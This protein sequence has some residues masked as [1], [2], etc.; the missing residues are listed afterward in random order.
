MP[1]VSNS[2]QTLPPVRSGVV[3]R[4]L[5]S[6]AVFGFIGQYIGH[7][8]G[9]HIENNKVAGPAFRWAM[10]AF[11]ALLASYSSLKASAM[12]R[13]EIITETP[14][15]A[16]VVSAPTPPTLVNGPMSLVETAALQDQ[17]KL[18]A[19]PQLQLAAK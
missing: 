8:L 14:L 19:M 7:Q 10:G 6:A 4:A 1:V 13:G 5:V 16:P 12:E 9:R 3:T 15:P 11:W 2:T 17:G 18:Q